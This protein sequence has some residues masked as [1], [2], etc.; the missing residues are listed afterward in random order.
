MGGRLFTFHATGGEEVPAVQE[1]RMPQVGGCCWTCAFCAFFR[2]T[3]SRGATYSGLICRG[4]C[5]TCCGWGLKVPVPLSVLTF[6]VPY[7]WSH[8]WSCVYW[9]EWRALP[10]EQQFLDFASL[11][12]LG[13]L[14]VFP[15]WAT[16]ICSP[17]C[18]WVGSFWDVGSAV[19]VGLPRSRS[20]GN[21]RDVIAQRRL[22]ARRTVRRSG[23]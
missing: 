14:F 20:G 1:K 15:C 18:R 23:Q 13:V 17:C 22:A 3:I 8:G 19:V 10:V 2:T 9:S 11:F 12:F 4:R 7:C 6:S 16:A 5:R 21:L